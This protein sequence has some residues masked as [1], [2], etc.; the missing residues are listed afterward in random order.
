MIGIPRTSETSII[1]L[2]WFGVEVTTNLPSGVK[3]NHA[4]PEPNRVAAA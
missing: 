4:H 2:S 1:G 3:T